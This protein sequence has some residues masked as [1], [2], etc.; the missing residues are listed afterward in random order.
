MRLHQREHERV[1]TLLA[2]ADALGPQWI[3]LYGDQGSGKKELI[4][5]LLEGELQEWPL[6]FYHDFNSFPIHSFAQAERVLQNALSE[7]A[8]AFANFLSHN[9]PS[10]RRFIRAYFDKEI[11]VEMPFVPAQWWSFDIW[12][13]YLAAAG[14]EQR[15][16]VILEGLF[17]NKSE[18]LREFLLRLNG[19][20]RPLAILTTGREKLR[21]GLVN[22]SLHQ[23]GVHK[24]P[25]RETE[26]LIAAFLETSP[27]NARMI[28][29][30]LHIKSKGNLRVIKFMTEAYY[31]PLLRARPGKSLDNIGLQKVRLSGAMEEVFEGLLESQAQP[32]RDFLGFLC[33]LE[34]PLLA[35]TA[36]EVLKALRIPEETYQTW[37]KCEIIS[38]RRFL[39]EP[40]VLILWEP[41]KNFLQRNTTV[42]RLEPILQ[43][44]Q[45]LPEAG[46]Q[47]YP[48]QLSDIF[49]AA[50][51]LEEAMQ[52]AHREARFFMEIGEE[53]RAMYRL[54]LLRRNLLQ[55]P[56][57]G[58][59][60]NEVLEKLGH[61]Q[62]RQG[63]F[64]H[65]FE[66]F[67]ELRDRLR[68]EERQKWV[69]ASLQMADSL[70]QMDALAEARYLLQELKIK[71]DVS[72]GSG[73]F[74]NVLLGE[75]EQNRGHA[76]YA[77]RYFEAAL[78]MLPGI[79]DEQLIQRLYRL[80][81]QFF[82]DHTGAAHLVKM[83]EHMIKELPQGSCYRQVLQL[84]LTRVHLAANDFSAALL[85]A[86]A[87]YHGAMKA[88]LPGIAARAGLYLAE[89]YGILGKWHLSRSHLRRMQ[90]SA[91]LLPQAR[92]RMQMIISLGVV[93]KEIGNYGEA[94]LLF[95]DSLR[96]CARN[97]WERETYQVRVHIGHIYL[98]VSGFMQARENLNEALQWAEEHEDEELI[99]LASLFLS[100]Y[101]LQQERSDSALDYLNKAKAA[102][103]LHGGMV[104]EL[105]Y[106]YYLVC[107]QMQAGKWEELAETVRRWEQRSKGVV[108][109]EILAQWLGGRAL[110]QRAALGK[111][112]FRLEAAL[113]RILPLRLPYVEFQIL[114]D[115][116]V[117][118]REQ[119]NQRASHLYMR[120][121]QQACERLLQRIHDEILQRQFRESRDYG[122][123]L[124]L[125]RQKTVS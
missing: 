95:Q 119:D 34:Q 44:L 13:E 111:A 47:K 31:A 25:I 99:I 6:L 42:D 123:F 1:L 49:F 50:G 102:L 100:A 39:G 18:I 114:R 110:M 91:A 122:E 24:L 94:L 66:S 79:D 3:H 98:L 77:R 30:H 46:R 8:D 106:H 22:A 125:S 28:T 83:I 5:S 14:G 85:T 92:Q 75:L 74:A 88:A 32:Q 96:A 105:N 124:E 121:A 108:K 51:L 52:F 16:L 17:E 2:E 68:R 97:G 67:R 54:A 64:E 26:K 36:R 12:L 70:F 56:A 23:I 20:R 19:L 53:E 57:A 113:K 118:E 11:P 33:R 82:L 71:E 115:L 45:T 58:I 10:L 81:R 9:P 93:E 15:P 55:Y 63:L 61:L 78:A 37:L 101:E 35:S 76:R 41:W 69:D 7:Q 103:D 86:L 87:V 60:I 73:V 107:Y 109:F 72:A 84:E 62:K 89:I 116:A 43:K 65:A 48:L 21:P 90:R 59:S 40:Y 112:K 117:L 38:E 29:N 104:E 27:F 120:R 4:Q 80:G